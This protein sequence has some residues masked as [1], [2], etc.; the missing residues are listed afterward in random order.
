MV[1]SNARPKEGDAIEG[2]DGTN[3]DEVTV[4]VAERGAGKQMPYVHQPAV[5][6]NLAEINVQC[7]S[8]GE[9]SSDME[10]VG[11]WIDSK[12][13]AAFNVASDDGESEEENEGALHTVRPD[14]SALPNSQ[15]HQ[16]L[17]DVSCR[18]PYRRG[19]VFYIKGNIITGIV[20]W[21]ASDLLERARDVIRLKANINFADTNLNII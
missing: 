14:S 21:N 16:L 1:S 13:G 2:G 19:A 10:T 6:S 3:Q 8:V 20:L 12:Y 18:S 5:R 15:Q 11:V 17:S 9:C 7:E 4:E